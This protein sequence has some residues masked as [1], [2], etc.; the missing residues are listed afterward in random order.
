MLENQALSKRDSTDR[1]YPSFFIY[2]H[3]VSL[4]REIKMNN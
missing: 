2:L 1:Y 3:S 4:Q